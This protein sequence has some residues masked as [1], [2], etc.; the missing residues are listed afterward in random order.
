M[1]PLASP[2]YV[3]EESEPGQTSDRIHY[4]AVTASIGISTK[5][6]GV[7]KYRSIK[8]AY[9]TGWFIMCDGPRLIKNAPIVLC[10]FEEPRFFFLF[11]F[12]HRLRGCM[13]MCVV[14]QLIKRAVSSLWSAPVNGDHSHI[15]SDCIRLSGSPS[16]IHYSTT[17]RPAHVDCV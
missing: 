13:C 1:W 10:A 9:Q 11:F 5:T 15:R 2:W 14:D 7:W 4:R 17:R 6:P 12:F 3:E 16:L 8:A